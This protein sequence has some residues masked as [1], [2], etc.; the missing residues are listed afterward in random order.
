M[1]THMGAENDKQNFSQIFLI[2]KIL[3]NIK[4]FI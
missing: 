3:V 2:A 4:Q 1:S